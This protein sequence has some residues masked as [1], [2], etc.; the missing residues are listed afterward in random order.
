[1]QKKKR[2]AKKRRTTSE[3]D[4]MVN[5]TIDGKGDSK[6]KTGIPF[7]DHMLTLFAKHGLF[8]L[9]I[10]AKGDLEV[11]MH[12]TNEDIGIA[13]GKAFEK[14]LGKKEGI[15]RFGEKT[16]PMDEALVRVVVDI[17]GRPFLN[18]SWA[19]IDL[20]TK[21]TECYTMQSARHF[22][23]SMVNNFPITMN[24]SV[25]SVGFDLHHLI[26]ATFKATAKALDEA[27]QIDPRVK[28]VP[29]TKGRL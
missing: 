12:H 8:D 25:L 21:D 2:K 7:L 18:S 28:G 17:S 29:S 15:R 19:D 27:T 20:E 11:D 1:M 3:T 10:K 13:L 5:L 16:V 24:I 6:I 4:I 9:E 23:Q 14:A 26:E 22:F